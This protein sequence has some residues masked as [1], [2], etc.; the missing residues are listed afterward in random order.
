MKPIRMFLLFAVF[1]STVAVSGQRAASRGNAPADIV[2]AQPGQL[3]TP[4]DFG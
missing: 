2:Y 3:A 1:I 4:V